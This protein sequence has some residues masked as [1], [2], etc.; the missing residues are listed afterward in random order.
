MKKVLTTATLVVALC[1]A[2]AFAADMPTKAPVQADHESPL[3]FTL[4]FGGSWNS[5]PSVNSSSGFYTGDIK[6][7]I[8]YYVSLGASVPIGKV[9]AYDVRVGPTIEW[10]QGSFHFSGLAG[11]VPETL[12]GRQDQLNYLAT[13]M[14]STKIGPKTEFYLGPVLGYAEVATH[15]TPCFGCPHYRDP[16][17]FVWGGNLGVEYN[18]GPD[19]DVG[20]T[21]SYRRTSSTDNKTE[22]LEVFRNGANNTIMAGLYVKCSPGRLLICGSD[23]RLKRDID[24]LTTLDSGMK[25]YSFKYLWDDTTYVGVMAQDLLENPAWRDA[26]ITSPNGFYAV[27]Y[28]ALGLK[29]VTLEEWQAQGLA[30]IKGGERQ[31][32]MQQPQALQPAL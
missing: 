8:G 23:I 9:G 26:V 2:P 13:M 16:G 12:S 22:T 1:G 31:S 10:M 11:G 18:V 15:G 5:G 32:V 25:I 28:G 3:D 17:T 19:L 24:L 4:A 30:S 27:N 7:F 21:V 14:F 20:Y 29:M 6:S